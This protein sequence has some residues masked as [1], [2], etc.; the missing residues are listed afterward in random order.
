VEQLRGADA[1]EQLIRLHA[2]EVHRYLSKLTAGDRV[3]TEDLV[4]E[5]FVTLVR[6]PVDDGVERF[7][8][9]WLL[10][11]ARSRFVDHV[12]SA[13]ARSR[14]EHRDYNASVE[15]D[16]SVDAQVVSGEQARWMLSQLPEAERWA[17]ALAVVEGMPVD[18]LAEVLGRS[19]AATHSLL[20]RGRRRLRSIMEGELR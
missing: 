6:Q 19:K 12:R 13:T 10:T 7:G 14:R 8:L 20:A 18:E 11:V 1:I 4:Q 16:G 3:L 5:V 9:P 15:S 17:L 2:A